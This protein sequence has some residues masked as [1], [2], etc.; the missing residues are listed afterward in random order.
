MPGEVRPKRHHTWVLVAG[1]GKHRGVLQEACFAAEAVGRAIAQHDCGLVTG[2]WPGVD[3]IAAEAFS[4]VEASRGNRLEHRL[5]QVVREDRPIHFQ[6]G[7]IVRTSVGPLEWLEPQSYCDAVVLIGGLGG[8]YGSFLSALHKGIPRFPLGGTGGD[9][10]RA[11]KEMCELWDLIPNPG[12]AKTQFETLAE[13]TS[14]RDRAEAVAAKLVPLVLQSVL[15]RQGDTPRSVF[16]SYSRRDAVWLERVCSI[17]QPVERKGLIKC[18]TDVQ[19]EAG[20]QWDAALRRQMAVCDIAILLVSASFLSSDYVNRIEL[21]TLIE[22]AR[23][24]ATRLLWVL[25][26]PCNWSDTALRHIQAALPTSA[27][28]SELEPTELQICLVKLRQLVES[29]TQQQQQSAKTEA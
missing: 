18:W 16:I 15:H 24:G 9:A 7:R 20:A 17:L 8:T 12:V 26:S 3:Y 28:L 1:T 4:Q 22:R 13:V 21:P 14:T 23:V 29:A 5:V 2:G 11:F 27:P 6:Q 19:V 10:E 25:L